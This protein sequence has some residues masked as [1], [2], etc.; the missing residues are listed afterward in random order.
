MTDFKTKLTAK[1]AERGM[2]GRQDLD[3]ADAKSLEG[4]R[5][6]RVLATYSSLYG[7]PSIPDVQG[8]LKGRMAEMSASVSVRPE[9]V[10]VYPER[11]FVTFVVEQPSVRLPLSASV[12][13]VAAGVDQFLDAQSN[14]WEVVNAETGSYITKKDEATVEQMIGLRKKALTTKQAGRKPLLA[15]VE[16]LPCVSGGYSEVSL[17]DVVDFY[18]GGSIRRG[19]IKSAGEPGVKIQL[20][21]G[22]DT[23]TVDPQAI[24]QLIERSS[25]ALTD[26]DNN[27]RRYWAFVYPG[28]EKMAEIITP[29]ASKPAKN[30]RGVEEMPTSASVVS[31]KAEVAARPTMRTGAQAVQVRVGQRVSSVVKR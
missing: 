4:G 21:I 2:Y 9:T 19:T 14:L 17:G 31:A 10:A 3:L 11:S 26:E 29:N 24:T 18:Y 13:M 20:L 16:T 25:G 22:N 27:L 1:Y 23:F 8:W 5:A 30:E 15:S 7:A 6:V 12:Q 28:N